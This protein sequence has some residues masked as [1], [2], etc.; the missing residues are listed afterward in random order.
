MPAAPA[1]TAARPERLLLGGG[2]LAAGLLVALTARRGPYAPPAEAAGAAPLRL[3]ATPGRAALLDRALRGLAAAC[4]ETGRALPEVAVA[5]VDDDQV[6]LSLIGAAGAPPAPWTQVVRRPGLGRAGRD[7][8]DGLATPPAPRTRRWPAS[9]VTATPTCWS[10]WRPRPGWSRSRATRRGA[11]RRGLAR[12]S[13]SPR[14][15]GPTAS[16]DRCRLRRRPHRAAPGRVSR[17]RA[18]RQLLGR[19]S[20]RPAP[21]RVALRT[22]GVRAC[23]P[24]GWCAAPPAARR[25]SSC[26]PGRRPPARPPGC[27]PWSPAAAPRWPSSAWARADRPL[28]LHRR[29]CR[30]ID[31]GVLGLR[32]SAAGCPGRLPPVLAALRRPTPPA[33]GAPARARSRRG[34]RSRRS[35]ARRRAAPRSPRLRRAPGAPRAAPVG[36]R[37]LGP[38]EVLAPG[39]VDPAAR[40]LLTE[41]V[42]AAALHPE[43]LHEAVLRAEVWPRG[44]GDDVLAATLAQAQAWLG[45]RA[46]RSAAAAARTRAGAPSPPTCTPTGTC[47]SPGAAPADGPAEERCAGG[48]APCPARRSPARRDRFASW[49]ST[50]P[51]ATRGSSGRRWPGA[52][53]PSRPRGDRAA[54]AGAARRA[55][56]RAGR[57]A[58]LA[59]PAAAD[60]RRAGG[61]AAVADGLTPRWPQPGCGRSPRPTPS[62]PRWCRRG[63][64]PRPDR[65]AYARCHAQVGREALV[66]LTLT[67][68]D[69]TTAGRL[70]VLVDADPDDPVAAVA[71]SLVAAARGVP[72]AAGGT[73]LALRPA[74][75]GGLLHVDGEPVDPSLAVRDSPLRD[76]AVVSLDGPEGCLLPEP[77]GL[78][79]LRVVGGPGR[80]DGGPAR[81]GHGHRRQ[82][83]RLHRPAARPD[84]A[85]RLLPARGRPR[86]RRGRR[87]DGRSGCPRSTAR[88]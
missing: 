48:L 81:A 61:A 68:V 36:V 51:P 54:R 78:V 64:A 85:G 44:V 20:S 16:R 67:V 73:V 12:A 82:R 4:A 63:S 22:L 28:A 74:R 17:R 35:P 53:P 58:A 11:R 3:A 65:T 47:C 77:D 21:P 60:R 80:R 83:R 75:V 38:V 7:L 55:A 56:A 59:R 76:G 87:R 31:L 66:Q 30:H 69:P 5:Y 37:L 40:P 79:E 14:T 18:R 84:R 10:T 15:S 62:S 49:R 27:T 86:R 2:L 52:P 26:C 13:S 25:T 42:V 57:G 45:T 9:P 72:A 19:W 1:T 71:E 32:A 34:R 23:C 24:A 33:P 43:G 39:P 88:R 41:I 6:T 8:P 46:G 29:R 70:D 50:A